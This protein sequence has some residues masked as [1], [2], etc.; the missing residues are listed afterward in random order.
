MPLTAHYLV[1]NVPRY[2]KGGG[3]NTPSLSIHCIFF[4]LRISYIIISHVL[5]NR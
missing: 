3:G 2:L 5:E 4:R 1:A